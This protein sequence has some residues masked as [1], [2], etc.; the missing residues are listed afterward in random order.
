MQTVLEPNPQVLQVKQG[1]V[2]RYLG[3]NAVDVNQEFLWVKGIPRTY[4]L[5]LVQRANYLLNAVQTQSG[6]WAGTIAT[7]ETVDKNQLLQWNV[8]VRKSRP[9]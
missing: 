8:L 2:E 3:L 5:D 7:V 9:R 1:D 4:S 6:A